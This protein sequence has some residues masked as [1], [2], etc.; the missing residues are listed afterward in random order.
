MTD[1][2][3]VLLISCSAGS[4]VA[5]LVLVRPGALRIACRIESL[6]VVCGMR[7]LYLFVCCTSLVDARLVAGRA[8]GCGLTSRRL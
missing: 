2:A 7:S 8:P 6:F 1:H 4:S 5:A 3:I